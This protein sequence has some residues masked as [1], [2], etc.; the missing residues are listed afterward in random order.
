[1]PILDFDQWPEVGFKGMV[2]K[3]LK[4]RSGVAGPST[5]LAAVVA[6]VV[7]AAI[8]QSDFLEYLTR[9]EK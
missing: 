3:Q 4:P 5:S 6:P 2:S 1:M 7:E 9:S 8:L